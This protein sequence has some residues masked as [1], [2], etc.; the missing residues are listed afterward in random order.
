MRLSSKST[1]YSKTLWKISLIAYLIKIRGS[2]QH[3]KLLKSKLLMLKTRYKTRKWKKSLLSK[4]RTYIEE[5]NLTPARTDLRRKALH[6]I[7]RAKRETISTKLETKDNHHIR[8]NL[9]IKIS[10]FSL[11]W[12]RDRIKDHQIEI[13]ALSQENLS[14]QGAHTHLVLRSGRKTCKNGLKQQIH[15]N[16]ALK[17][18]FKTLKKSMI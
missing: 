7:L 11:L 18:L 1:M 2:Q 8:G 12:T 14:C 16:I 5:T 17:S 6:S 9:L 15:Q 3:Q 4:I 10:S 13:S